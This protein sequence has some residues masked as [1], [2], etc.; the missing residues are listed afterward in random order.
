MG[1][2]TRSPLRRGRCSGQPT[3]TASDRLKDAE[4]IDALHV[5]GQQPRLQHTESDEPCGTGEAGRVIRSEQVVV[6]RLRHADPLHW[7]TV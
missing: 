4:L 1:R 2:V 7:V 6:D 3:G 5:A